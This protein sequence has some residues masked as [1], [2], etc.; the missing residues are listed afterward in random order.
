[1][2][3]IFL[4]IKRE[5]LTKVK[6]KSFIVMTILGPILMASLFILPVYLASR[7]DDKQLISVVDETGLFADK[8]QNNEN[9]TF[10]TLT[11]NLQQA[12]ES[13]SNNGDYML[14]HIPATQTANTKP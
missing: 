14:L 8:F 3:K 4:I 5:Y 2:N 7:Q 10:V 1:M 13:L 6:K 9:Y 12:K 11:E